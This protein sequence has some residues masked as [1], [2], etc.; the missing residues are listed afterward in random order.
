MKRNSIILIL[1]LSFSLVGCS[2]YQRVQ[3]TYI[4]VVGTWKYKDESFGSPV[5]LT[6]NRDYTYQLDTNKDGKKDVWGTYKIFHNQIKFHD[7]DDS[8]SAKVCFEPGVY[9]YDVSGYDVYYQLVADQ[10][11]YRAAALS[12]SWTRVKK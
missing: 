12:Y 10:C 2:I 4:D 11:P 6:M 1:L 7:H 5:T 3:G 9:Y 8:K